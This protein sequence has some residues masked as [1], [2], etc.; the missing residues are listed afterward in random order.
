VSAA[1]ASVGEEYA[2]ADAALEI[3]QMAKRLA[4]IFADIGEAEEKMSQALDKCEYSSLILE[5]KGINTVMLATLLGEAGDISG[6]ESP[7]QLERLAGINLV[8][9]SSGQHKSKTRISKRG[10][11]RQY[12]VKA[13]RLQIVN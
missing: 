13:S 8:E 12:V 4:S 1:Q 2:Q 6:F 9:N 10:R 5:M 11:P 3:A 7:R